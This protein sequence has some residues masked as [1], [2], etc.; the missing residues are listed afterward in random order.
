MGVGKA[1]RESAV[2]RPAVVWLLAGIWVLRL[3]I[4]DGGGLWEPMAF[5]ALR[6]IPGERSR[7]P[8]L[9]GMPQGQGPIPQ[10]AVSFYSTPLRYKTTHIYSCSS[11][12]SGI[13]NPATMQTALASSSRGLTLTRA[14]EA[15]GCVLL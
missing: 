14:G 6:T 4:T 10:I 7:M 12:L 8:E 11:L 13:H 15:I 2:L 5:A 9:H 1:E 3:T